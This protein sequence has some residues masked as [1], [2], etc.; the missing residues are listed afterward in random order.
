[1]TQPDS[2]IENPSAAI[3][4]QESGT[5]WLSVLQFVFSTLAVVGLWGFALL[6]LA[7]GLMNDAPGS[8]TL[9]NTLSLF[10]ISAIAFAGGLLVVPSSVLSL[11]R[12]TGRQ[13]TS[14]PRFL[15]RIRP[16]RIIFAFPLVLLLGHLV[17][18]YTDFSWLLLPALHVLAVLIPISWLLY[19]LV[20]GIPLGSPQRSWGVFDSGLVLGPILVLFTELLALA[21]LIT[22]A[23]IYI[24]NQ[25]GLYDEI[26]SLMEE[27]STV[28]PSSEAIIQLLTPYLASPWTLFAV[29]AFAA[30]VVPL[31]EEAIKPIGVWLLIGHELSPAE[32][33]A[34][35]AL[36][37]AGF[38]LFESLMITS[39]GTDWAISVVV[40]ISTAIIHI[41]TASLMGWALVTAWSQ[42]R[43]IK[44]GVTYLGVVL[45]H[46]TWN[47][48]TLI[49]TANDLLPQFGQSPVHPLLS[50]IGTLAPYILGLITIIVFIAILQANHYFRSAGNGDTRV[51]QNAQN[52]TGV[53]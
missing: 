44:L 38:A 6:S 23:F 41:F 26:M 25:P 27:L 22:F 14:S 39:G 1:M 11:R 13:V 45:L 46:G 15:S 18:T 19:L 4:Y 2:P 10:L 20:R 33:F 12:I 40:R 3:Q 17:I 47:G 16:G 36:S 31:I 24:F 53:S 28:A 48:L 51:E 7:L 37:G 8:G 52:S 35:G 30:V 42:K 32:G 21:A 50:T 9:N 29:L 43:Y 49:M 34:A 5:H